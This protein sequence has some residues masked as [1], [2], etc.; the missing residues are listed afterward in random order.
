[1]TASTA[2][3]TINARRGSIKAPCARAARAAV[4]T[5]TAVAGVAVSTI[6]KTLTANTGIPAS[7]TGTANTTI[8]PQ[9]R[10]R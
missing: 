10:I 9:R 4:A 1:M 2:D 5:I 3:T 7:T 6:D 8:S